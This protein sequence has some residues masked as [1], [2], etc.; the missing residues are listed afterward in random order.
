MHALEIAGCTGEIRLGLA[1]LGLRLQD[2]LPP[3]S[4][5]AQAEL[6]LGQGALGVRRLAG[7]QGVDGVDPGDLLAGVDHRPLVN[8]QLLQGA[9]HFGRDQNLGGLDMARCEDAPVF[10]SLRSQRRGGRFAGR[11]RLSAS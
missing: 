7:E 11:R 1:E 9:S 8:G 5:K 4:G 3:R 2:V 10:V 6:G